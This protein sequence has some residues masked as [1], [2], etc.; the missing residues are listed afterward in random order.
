MV[1]W[2]GFNIE[3]NAI[4]F[5]PL[6]YI[7]GMIKMFGWEKNH[8]IMVKKRASISKYTKMFYIYNVWYICVWWMRSTLALVLPI[9]ETMLNATPTWVHRICFG[10]WVLAFGAFWCAF[11]LY[12]QSQNSAQECMMGATY[13]QLNIRTL[14]N[15]QNVPNKTNYFGLHKEFRSSF[16]RHIHS[17]GLNAWSSHTVSNVQGMLLAFCIS[18]MFHHCMCK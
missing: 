18:L 13:A 5:S 3:T 2:F 4:F 16:W 14:L 12:N 6:R 15:I 7:I 9:P 8:L 17:V 11:R 1:I 10:H